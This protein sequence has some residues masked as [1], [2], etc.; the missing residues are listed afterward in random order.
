VILAGVAAGYLTV[1]L[2]A[3]ALQPG[4]V[5]TWWYA[6]DLNHRNDVTA[7]NTTQ[8]TVPIRSGERQGYVVSLYNP[9]SVTETIVADG[10]GRSAGWDHPGGSQNS[11][12]AVSV[13]FWNPQDSLG[14]G[15]VHNVRYALPGAIPPHQTR[16][17]RV[18]WTSDLC[19]GK[20]ESTGIDTLFLRVRVGWFTRTETIPLDNGWYLVGPSHGRCV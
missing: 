15:L 13:R 10:S 17:L 12:I 16:L 19:L 3:G 14:S 18:I 11:Q 1:F 8:S 4:F 5:H 7:D 2:T 6:Q 9:T 20:G